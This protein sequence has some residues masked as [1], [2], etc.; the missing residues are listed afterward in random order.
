MSSQRIRF[1]EARTART[2]AV[3]AL[4]ALLI[5]ALAIGIVI[6]TMFART[7]LGE[8]QALAARRSYEIEQLGRI[9]ANLSALGPR[10]AAL[11]AQLSELRDFD[12]RLKGSSGGG[13]AQGVHDVP[14]L[15]DS[16]EP[17][18]SLDGAGGPE[19]PPRLCETD[20]ASEG[21]PSQRL[22]RAAKAVDC[23][24]DTLSQLQS[25]T[26][27][28]YVAYM[29]FPGR[30][31]APGARFGSPYGNRIDPFTG[32]ASFHPG[33][34]LVAPT[35]TAILASAGGRVVQAGERNGYGNA[36]DI[37]HANGIVTRYGHASRVLVKEGQFV[38][39][40]DEI[41]EVGSTGRSTG[42]HLHFEVIVGGAQIDPKP[43]LS[44]FTHKPNAKG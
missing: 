17:A 27:A 33:L 29:A 7:H 22:K 19:L 2:I 43:Y 40:G 35:G 38:M 31:P 4:V 5:A 14:P 12:I 10:V 8:K 36:V 23:L 25:Q 34:D 32:H 37:R 41:A 30:D 21:T 3:V 16:Q 28:H 26:V 18:T 6:G 42:P 11:A 39:P 44:L 20:H 15:P 13:N 9:D 24:D 1:V